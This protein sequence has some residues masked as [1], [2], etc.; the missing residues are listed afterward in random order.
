MDFLS[1]TLCNKAN[2]DP[3]QRVKYEAWKKRETGQICMD[4]LFSDISHLMMCVCLIFK[5]NSI[6]DY[7]FAIISSQ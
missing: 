7:K 2:F 6:E 4:R 1:L 5:K 3:L